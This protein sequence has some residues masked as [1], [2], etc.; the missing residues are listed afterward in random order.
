MEL[1]LYQKDGAHYDLV[2]SP[3][4]VFSQSEGKMFSDG[5]VEVT[6][7]VPI[8]GTPPHPLTSI[9]TTGIAFDTKSGKADTDKPASFKFENGYGTCL[10][11]FYDP[12]VHEMH[13]NSQVDVYLT[14]KGKRSKTMHVQTERLVYQEAA[15]KIFLGPWSKLT[16]ENTVVDAAGSIINLKD[17]LIDTIDAD[18]AHGVDSY[19]KRHL[20]YAA[21]MLHLTYDDDGELQK[22]TG[23]GNARVTSE[24]KGSPT[25]V[26]PTPSIFSLKRKTMRMFCGGPSPTA[27]RRWKPSP[28]PLRTANW[29]R[30]KSSTA[31]PS[32]SRCAPAAMN[33]RRWRPTFPPPWNFCPTNPPSIAASCMA[34]R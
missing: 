22:M 18:H 28:S 25:T 29:P 23:T 26:R 9:K 15:S 11:L 32:S 17:K 7:N 33:S 30:P 12:E 4:A 16:R 19:P 2:T 6:L 20:N 1:K 5:E 8:Q 31:R 21:D 10:G 14:G 24:S 13:M 34:P 27:A 3:K